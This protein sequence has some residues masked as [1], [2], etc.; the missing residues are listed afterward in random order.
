MTMSDKE[1]LQWM[2]DRL[3]HRHGEDP[4]FD[5]MHKLRAIIDSTPEDKVTPNIASCTKNNEKE[6]T[7]NFYTP[8]EGGIWYPYKGEAV[9]E[10]QLNSFV[11]CA[12]KQNGTTVVKA[13]GV[14]FHSL[15]FCG[16]DGSSRWDIKN[17]WTNNL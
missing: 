1:F 6:L 3:Q 5:Y 16:K 9:T 17:G 10:E 7:P 8:N 12:K 4:H 2:H 13:L 14:T 11:E 15:F